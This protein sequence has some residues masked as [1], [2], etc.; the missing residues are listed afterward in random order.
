MQGDHPHVPAVQPGAAIPNSVPRTLNNLVRRLSARRHANNIRRYS[1]AHAGAILP[2]PGALQM[3]VEREEELPTGKIS[4]LE[5]RPE[6]GADNVRHVENR[7]N[8]KV[9]ERF[10]SKRVIRETI[11]FTREI[12]ESIRLKEIRATEIQ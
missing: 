3:G 11:E 5:T 12:T 4:Q 7:K 2:F 10:G 1:V 6:R 8:G 9:H